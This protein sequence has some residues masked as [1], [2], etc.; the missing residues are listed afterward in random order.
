MPPIANPFNA[1]STPVPKPPA[2]PAT[3][4]SFLAMMSPFPS[5]SS[6]TLNSLI[7]NFNTSVLLSPS[8]LATSLSINKT[9]YS[10]KN[11]PC[12]LPLK[13]RSPMTNFSTVLIL[14]SRMFILKSRRSPP[15]KM[16][17]FTLA[18]NWPHYLT[19]SFVLNLSFIAALIPIAM[20]SSL[21]LGNV[22]Y[23]TSSHARIAGNSSTT[24]M[25]R[26][27]SAIPTL[28]LLL[29]FSRPTPNLAPIAKFLFT[30][31][32]DATKCSALSANAFGHG[33]PGNLKLADTILTT[34]NGCAI[35]MPPACPEKPAK[36]CVDK[37]L[38]LNSLFYFIAIWYPFNTHSWLANNGMMTLLNT[39][40][41]S[42]P[43]SLPSLICAF[44]NF[45]ASPLTALPSIFP[46][47]KLSLPTLC[48]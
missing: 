47:A 46:L 10:L 25:T 39:S 38:T 45:H 37:K 7:L 36:F 48:H 17:S 30:K 33:N 21:P 40:A 12:F 18:D 3:R 16:T 29:H 23:A 1:L 24:E 28:S 6:A 22:A 42:S 8:S 41:P 15:S 14:K 31:R 2:A 34:C 9:F 44:M 13:P 26:S 20:A 19:L 35:T 27:M 11:K 5:A 4:L 32:K 43:C